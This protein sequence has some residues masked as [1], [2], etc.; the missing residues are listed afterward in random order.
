MTVLFARAATE[1]ATLVSFVPRD[2]FE[3]PGLGEW[4]LCEL[5]GHTSR[6]LSTVVDYLAQP[7]PPQITVGSATEYLEVVLRRRGDDEAIM[8]RG[9]TAAAAL[10]DDP[11]SAIAELATAAVHAVEAAGTDR[12]IAVGGGPD[13]VAMALGEYLRTR[14]FEL[15]VHGIDIADAAGLEWAPAPAHVLDALHLAAANASARGAGV[16]ALRLLTGRRP[17]AGLDG[18]LAAG[19]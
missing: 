17:D 18:V 6:A 2:R 11:A 15:T 5:I 7:A 10:G 14:A 19:R 8:L 3:G 13:P 16:E 4:T 9:R 12:L 1:F